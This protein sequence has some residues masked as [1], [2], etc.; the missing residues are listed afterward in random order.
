MEIAVHARPVPFNLL[1]LTFFCK[2]TR[3]TVVVL[4]R[5]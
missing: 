3:V 2:S 4:P 1:A 5:N